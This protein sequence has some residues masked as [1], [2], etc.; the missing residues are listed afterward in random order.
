MQG[1]LGLAQWQQ[2]WFPLLILLVASSYLIYKA[3]DLNAMTLGDESA[4]T[5][6]VAVN[7]FRLQ[8]IVVCALLTGAAVAFSGVIGFVGL[9]VPHVVRLLVGGDYRN[10]LPLSALLGGIFLVI[11]DMASRTLIPPEELPVGIITGLVGGFA[12]IFLMRKSQQSD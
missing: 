7:R 1:C 8:V 11:A 3:R 5:L 4:Y 6:G 12:F 9:M 10:V 2:I